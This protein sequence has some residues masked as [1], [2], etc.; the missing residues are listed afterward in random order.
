MLPDP[1]LFSTWQDF[2]H[3]LT[4]E[5]TKV[6][7]VTGNQ[8]A[9]VV[10]YDQ[11]VGTEKPADGATAGATWGTDI[12][13][14]PADLGDINASEGTKLGGVATGATAGAT[15]DS[16]ITSQPANAT[17]DNVGVESASA[18]F[19]TDSSGV[20]PAGN[21]VTNL[22]V[23]FTGQASTRTVKGTLTTST[24]LITLANVSSTG[25]ATTIVASGSG[26]SDA[27]YVVTQTASGA[28]GIATWVAIDVDDAGSGG[29][30]PAK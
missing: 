17:I 14:E 4:R 15:W 25:L 20:W 5:L 9:A 24:G 29:S 27:K 16:N 18:A 10:D 8:V 6:Y 26:T 19:F 30:P 1:N 11:V 3:A 2:A 7:G 28:V 12:T 22:V 13:N 21:P 23:R